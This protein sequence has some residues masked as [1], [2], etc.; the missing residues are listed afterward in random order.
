MRYSHYLCVKPKQRNAGFTLVEVIIA[1]GILALIA[2]LSWRGLDAMSR[3]RNITNKN[4][5][6]MLTLQIALAQWRA[7]LDAVLPDAGNLAAN[8]NTNPNT[9]NKNEQKNTR[10]VPIDW[11]GNTL[12]IVR[13]ASL[14]NANSNNYTKGAQQPTPS[15]ATQNTELV[16]TATQIVAW[17]LQKSCPSNLAHA[18]TDKN[19]Q[20]GCWVRWQSPL[21]H[22]IGDQRNAWQQAAVWGAQTGNAQ[23]NA[24][25]VILPAKQ[26]QVYFFYQDEWAHPASTASALNETEWISPDGVRLVLDIAGTS[27]IQ[28]QITVDWLSPTL[29]R[30]RS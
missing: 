29:T 18:D 19:S 30:S 12:R 27:N 22:S 15:S 20:H 17:S 26:W 7:D 25:Q 8:T 11:N 9:K 21:L 1:M 28:G 23:T 4:S 24:T 5:A 10:F 13:R 16:S 14:T 6:H 2:V 3:T